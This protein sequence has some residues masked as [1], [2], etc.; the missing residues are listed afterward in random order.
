MQ[1]V[2]SLIVFQRLVLSALPIATAR[3]VMHFSVL[4]M[5]AKRA[6]VMNSVL[7]LIP[8]SLSAIL[9]MENV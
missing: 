1:T 9:M 2:P 3:R 4:T 7:L 8:A 5:H 6:A